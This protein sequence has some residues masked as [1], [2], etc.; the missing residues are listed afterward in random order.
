MRLAE[1]LIKR[2]SIGR[3]RLEQYKG[4][5]PGVQMR[6]VLEYVDANLGQDLT[7]NAIAEDAG[8]STYHLGKAFR[9]ATGDMAPPPRTRETRCVAA[10]S[11]T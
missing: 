5:L 6:R 1:E 3:P 7:G 4:G 2:Y 10:S 8:L 9:E 11:N